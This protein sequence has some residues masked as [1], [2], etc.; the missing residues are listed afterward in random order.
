MK[1]KIIFAGLLGL[2]VVLLGIS[3]I[4][5]VA[6]SLKQA[7]FEKGEAANKAGNYPEAVNWY[8]QSC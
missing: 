3:V 1:T 8:H 5:M 2:A 6:Q 7:D 4:G